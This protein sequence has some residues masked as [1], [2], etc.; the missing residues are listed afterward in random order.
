MWRQLAC[1]AAVLTAACGAPSTPV[2]VAGTSTDLQSLAGEWTGEYSSTETGRSGSIVFRLTAG[3][4]SA[5]GDVMMGPQGGVAGPGGSGAS[6]PEGARPTK[7]LTIRFVQV[8]GGTVRGRLDPYVEVECACTLL[9]VFNGELRGD[10]LSG[11]YTSRLQTTGQEQ[12][13][14]WKVTRGAR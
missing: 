9:T 14:R 8:E 3:T 13:G 7:V 10:T 12:H 1:A 4:D 11:S 6:T 2:P 5:T